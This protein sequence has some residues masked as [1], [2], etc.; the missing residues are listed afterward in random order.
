ME[1]IRNI[2]SMF[3]FFVFFQGV[4]RIKHKVAIH[5]KYKLYS[6]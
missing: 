6:K 3:V 1:L 4:V 2:A 5:T